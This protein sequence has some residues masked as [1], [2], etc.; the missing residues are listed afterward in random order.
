MRALELQIIISILLFAESRQTILFSATHIQQN[1]ALKALK[2]ENTLYVRT[3]VLNVTK[4]T[5]QSSLICPS[6]KRLAT[7]FTFLKK[8]QNQKVM[9]FFSSCASVE[10]HDTLF[11]NLELNVICIHVSVKKMWRNI[12]WI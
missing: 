3:K 10:Y 2:V 7:L 12:H 11:H 8:V 4:S 1:E 5:S 9:V 6:E